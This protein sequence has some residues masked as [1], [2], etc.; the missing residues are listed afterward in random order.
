MDIFSI[1]YDMNKDKNPKSNMDT[2][3]LDKEVIEF[4]IEKYEIKN[5]RNKKRRAEIKQKESEAIRVESDASK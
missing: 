2:Y 5:S 3:K 1:L 4:L